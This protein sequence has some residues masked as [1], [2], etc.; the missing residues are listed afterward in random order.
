MRQEQ[1][2]IVLDS[3]SL[4]DY[5]K[6]R[7][8]CPNFKY[9]SVKKDCFLNLINFVSENNFARNVKIAVPRIVLEE[10]QKQQKDMF[11][12]Q[13]QKLEQT[14]LPFQGLEGFSLIKPK[15]FN[16][17][18]FLDITCNNFVGKYNLIPIDFPDNLVLPK[19]IKK[20]INKDKPFYKNEADSGFKDAILW[21][22]LLKYAK[23]HPN[24]RYILLTNDNALKDDSLKSEFESETHTKLE[25]KENLA[26]VKS[27]LQEVIN[28]N[29][30]FNE[31]LN[32]YKNNYIFFYNFILRHLPEIKCNGRMFRIREI[33]LC[34]EPEDIT[35]SSGEY[36]LYVECYFNHD[37]EYTGWG[38][39]GDNTYSFYESDDSTEVIVFT[40]IKSNSLYNLKEV[41][42]LSN[43][44]ESILGINKPILRFEL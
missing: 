6:N 31:I 32:L 8:D 30:D 36:K 2:V 5:R 17:E 24:E 21:E 34:S 42:F 23:E 35:G 18:E 10:I 38:M 13:E 27:F 16:Y 41:G 12:S 15:N 3:N 43:R 19:L 29:K 11:R 40:I 33:K 20:V 14:F 28:Q 7:L 39:A 44:F 1:F 26:D 9:L 22:S 4:G 37:T 25:I